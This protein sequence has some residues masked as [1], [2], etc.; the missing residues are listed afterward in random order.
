MLREKEFLESVK[1]CPVVVY[2]EKD[3]PTEGYVVARKQGMLR[4]V[5]KS[6]LTNPTIIQS[7]SYKS[8]RDT[9]AAW[10]VVQESKVVA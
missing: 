1:K 5:P 2:L 10:A 3:R 8:T 9:L 7:L 4:I 6:A